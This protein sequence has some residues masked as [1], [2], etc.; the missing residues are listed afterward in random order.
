MVF[1]PGESIGGTRF[2]QVGPPHGGLSHLDPRRLA[3]VKMVSL[4][5]MV[6]PR[7]WVVEARRLSL[8]PIVGRLWG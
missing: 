6:E 7:R 2:S 4:A 1:E 8:P 3:W 5:Q